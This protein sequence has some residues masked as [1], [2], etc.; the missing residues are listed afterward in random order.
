MQIVM[1]ASG[2]RGDVQPMIA[3]G[4]SLKAKGHRV[5]L[6]AGSNFVEWIE[7]HGLDVYP[8]VDIEKLMRS[9]LG[10]KWVE[11]P[12]QREQLKALKLMTNTLIEETV[13]DTVEGTSGAELLI[14]GFLAQP[15]LHAISEKH[16]IPLITA[17]LQPFRPTSSGSASILPIL[18]RRSNILNRWMGLLG[19]RF[20]WSIVEETTNVLRGRLGLSPYSA[21][22]YSQASATIPALYAISPQVVPPTS[23]TNS[24]TTGYWF[25]DEPFTP[26]DDL[27]RFIENGEPPIYFGFGSMPD[28]NPS[29]TLAMVSD[30]LRRMGRRGVVVSGWSKMKAEQHDDRIYLLRGAPH[31]WLFP[32]MSA[33]VHHGG[34]GTVAA[35]LRAGKPALI[36]PHMGDQPFWARRLHELGVS[37]K[38]LSRYKTTSDSLTAQLDNLINNDGIYSRA[39]ALASDICA[40]RGVI[41]A[42]DGIEHFIN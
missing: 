20:T 35:G 21:R 4:K 38:P 26:A 31:D 11:S 19:E 42:V 12:N 28:S 13:H 25:L 10:I 15:Y 2:T 34:A 22:S 17:A 23:D 30:V 8:T 39:T 29:Q 18:P 27:V 7:S 5:R 16:G 14:G 37:P 41:N 1:M 32:R 3:L 40:E 6:I 33:L 9:D 24:Y 36:I